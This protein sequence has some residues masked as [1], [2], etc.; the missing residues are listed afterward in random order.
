MTEAVLPRNRALARP[1]SERLATLGVFFANGLGIGAWAAAIPRLKADL[2]LGD[3]ALSL[4]LLC[5]A[6]GAVVAMPLMGALA[7]RIPTG[8]ATCAA[9]LA[10]IASL[11]SPALA[12]SLTLLCAATL[13]VGAAN[14]AMDVAMNAHASDVERRWGRP[15]MS[16]FHAGFSLGGAVGAVLGARLGEGAAAAGFWGPALLGVILLAPAAGSLW[17][18]GGATRGTAL[19]LPG[20]RLLPLAALAL[21]AMMTE[22][23]IGDWSGS[24]LV[25]SG[26]PVALAAAGYVSFSLCMIAGRIFGDTIVGRAGPRATVAT[27]AILAAAGLRDR[28]RRARIGDRRPGLRTGR[29]GALQRRS[30]DLQC[31]GQSQRLRRCRH[32]LRRHCGL[33]RTSPRARGGRRDCGSRGPADGDRVSRVRGRVHSGDCDDGIDLAAHTAIGAGANSPIAKTPARRAAR[34]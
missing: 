1:W 5:F 20:R 15:I 19:A 9:G 31:G 3:G 7:A 23:A 30:G 13:I 28:R 12:G 29:G 14:G 11:A 10:F 27:G 24:Y 26:V 8:R 34:G 16:S 17:S 32:R 21:L 33:R 6:A 18:A 22:G 4:A 25:R 2:N